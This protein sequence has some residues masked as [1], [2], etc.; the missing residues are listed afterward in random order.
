MKK[1]KKKI[2]SKGKRKTCGVDKIVHVAIAFCF[3][4]ALLLFN[5][6]LLKTTSDQI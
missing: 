6:C 5:V 4:F 1:K 3:F 2:E